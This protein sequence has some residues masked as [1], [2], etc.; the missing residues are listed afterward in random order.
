MKSL[1]HN[2]FKPQKKKKKGNSAWFNP[3]DNTVM[4]KDVGSGPGRPR[5]KSYY[6]HSLAL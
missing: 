1:I 2:Y 3:L 5:F 6:C 4:L